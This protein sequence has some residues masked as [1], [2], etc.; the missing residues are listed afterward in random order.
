MCPGR[1]STSRDCKA[2]VVSEALGQMGLERPAGTHPEALL[3]QAKQLASSP[4]HLE[5]LEEGCE[6]RNK[7]KCPVF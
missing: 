4:E 7:V 1:G 3:H 5:E 2:E 6:W